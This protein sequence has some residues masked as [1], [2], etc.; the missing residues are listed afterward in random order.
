[1]KKLFLSACLFFLP[2]LA[3]GATQTYIPSTST[4]NP[5]VINIASGTIRNLNVSTM[6]VNAVVGGTTT[7]NGPISALAVSQIGIGPV[8]AAAVAVSGTGLNPPATYYYKVYPQQ[9]NGKVGLP[10][11]E[12]AVFVDTPTRNVSLSWPSV[13]NAVAYRVSRGPAQGGQSGYYQLG[14]TTTYLDTG[15]TLSVSG[16]NAFSESNSNALI[17]GGS[18]FL[19]ASSGPIKWYDYVNQQT[20]SFLGPTS[21]SEFEFNTS[22]GGISHGTYVFEDGGATFFSL[23]NIGGARLA[24]FVNGGPTQGWLKVNAASM[25]FVINDSLTN[26]FGFLPVGLDLGGGKALFLENSASDAASTISNPGNAGVRSIGFYVGATTASFIT[27]AGIFNSH[28]GLTVATTTANDQNSVYIINASGQYAKMRGTNTNDDGLNPDIGVYVS[29]QTA[30][31]TAVPI[32]GNWGNNVGIDLTAGD[33]DAT[34]CAAGVG[35][36]TTYGEIGISATSGNSSAGLTEGINQL[37]MN[38]PSATSD[39]SA[40]IANFRIKVAAGT[41]T[42]YYLKVNFNYSA[43]IPTYNGIISARRRR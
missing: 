14:N 26:T 15:A 3:K 21:A 10:S 22:T 13:Q 12:I 6:T 41:T 20:G 42:T 43:A 25:T 30:A 27:S 38:V 9:A 32:A 39:A 33:W 37:F 1:M 5:Y 16:Q 2:C 11:K 23:N 28:Q 7:F 18:I 40:C 8:T 34:A 36:N 24:S 17:V 31:F 29:S 35:T 4:F 19:P